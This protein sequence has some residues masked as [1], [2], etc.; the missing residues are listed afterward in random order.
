[1][2]RLAVHTQALNR[3]PSND[4]S[5]REEIAQAV[6]HYVDGAKSGRGEDM[7]LGFHPQA[8]IFGYL[9]DDLLAGPIQ[10]LYD[11]NDANGP[12]AELQAGIPKIDL[13]GTVATVRLELDNWTGSR[14]TD[15][16]TLLKVDVEWKIINKVFHLHP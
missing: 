9:G 1:M 14:Y 5:D 16:F 7:R 12:A 10:Q 8:T 15:F 2:T 3:P 4:Q 13:I 11:W 6:Q